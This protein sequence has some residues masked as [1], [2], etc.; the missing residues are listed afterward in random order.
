MNHSYIIGFQQVIQLVDCVAIIME[1]AENGEM[2]EYVQKRQRI[3]EL[4]TK[5]IMFQILLAVDYMHLNGIVHRDLKLENILLDANNLIKIAD[6]G[7]ANFMETVTESE[8]NNLSNNK[9]K[10]KLLKTSCGSPCY[11]APE[12]VLSNKVST[13]TNEMGTISKFLLYSV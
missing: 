2:F 3:P 7:F 6:F 13:L 5:R 11:A 4:E 9:E 8:R 10:L 12:I 1:Y